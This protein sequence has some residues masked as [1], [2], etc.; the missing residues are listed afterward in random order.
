MEA[1]ANRLGSW[2]LAAILVASVALRI[3]GMTHFAPHNDEVI[4]AE[5]AEIIALDWEAN[6]FVYQSGR[7]HLDYKEPLQYWANSLTVHMTQDPLIG[8]RIWSILLGAVGLFFLHRWVSRIWNESAA[9]LSAAIMAVSEYYFYFDSIAINEAFLYGLGAAFIYYTYDL[10][11]R[12]R[13]IS[14]ALS[15]LLLLGLL[16]TKGSGIQW[17]VLA[18]VLPVIVIVKWPKER[19]SDTSAVMQSLGGMAVR[20]TVIVLSARWLHGVVIPAKYT[21]IRDRKLARGYLR[22]FEEVFEFPIDEWWNSFSFYGH[23]VLVNEFSIFLVPVFAMLAGGGVLL[24]RSDSR[25]FICFLAVVAIYLASFVPLIFVAKTDFIRYYGVGLYFLHAALAIAIV[26]VLGRLSHRTRTIAA[27]GALTLVLGWKLAFS[28]IPLAEWGQTDLSFAE[29][30]AGWANGSGILELLDAVEA[31]EPGVVV[32]DFQ[33]GHPATALQ[34]YR[35]RFPQ[36]KFRRINKKWTRD[37]LENARKVLKTRDPT[38]YFVFDARK[39]R[40][41]RMIDALVLN[42]KLCGNNRVIRKTYKDQVMEDS[43]LLIC[44]ADLSLTPWPFQSR[45]AM[46]SSSH[47]V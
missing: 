24:Y 39:F 45:P 11:E 17:V 26:E 13:W 43:R 27:W 5:V 9:H 40:D 8:C 42:R 4:Y 37:P 46:K 29:T 22:S 2:T 44:T 25:R 33:W 47:P 35:H 30:P 34:I 15:L 12:S 38:V 10:L 23:E 7:H 31:L 28:W 41:R 14:G 32:M 16:L 18:C 6:K 1:P 19:L 36:H 21:A 3:F 20:L